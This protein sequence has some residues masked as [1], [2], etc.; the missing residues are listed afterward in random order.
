MKTLIYTFTIDGK[1]T[2][3]QVTYLY[4]YFKSMPNDKK[5]KLLL[6]IKNFEGF[7]SMQTFI[8]GIKTD[9]EI[10]G[11]IKKYAVL[12]EKHWLKGLIKLG[13]AVTPGLSL[14]VFSHAEET[15]AIEWLKGRKL[16]NRVVGNLAISALL[17]LMVIPFIYVAVDAISNKKTA[18]R[19]TIK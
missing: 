17:T 15:K 4:N 5:I 10:I 18:Y 8:K 6:D 9:F 14:K 3:E 2:E 13:E 12:T 1:L 11:N 16:S 7:E 19:N